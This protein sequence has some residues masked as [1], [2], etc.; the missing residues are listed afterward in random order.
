MK[1]VA[2]GIV[3]EGRW[4]PTKDFD[5]PDCKKKSPQGEIY[6]EHQIGWG[7]Y[8][9]RFLTYYAHLSKIDVKKGDRVTSGQ[10]IGQSGDSGCSSDPHLHFAVARTTNLSGYYRLDPTYP[11]SGYGISAPHGFIDPFHWT[12]P[13]GVNPGAWIALGDQWDGILNTNVKNAGLS[14]Y[15]SGKRDRNPSTNA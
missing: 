2:A 10:V 14:V 9:E 3:R 13:R 6:V 8:A 11:L 15:L 1:A 7:N 4:R 12:A 5:D